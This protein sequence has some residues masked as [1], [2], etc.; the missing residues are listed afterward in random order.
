[1]TSP[2]RSILLINSPILT[3]ATLRQLVSE[4]GETT[5]LHTAVVADMPARLQ[6]NPTALVIAPSHQLD[7]AWPSLYAQARFIGLLTADTPLTAPLVGV[8]YL[9]VPFTAV[10][11]RPHLTSPRLSHIHTQ[12]QREH[13]RREKAEAFLDLYKTA[14]DNSHNIILVLDPQAHII[15]ANE[16]FWQLHHKLG[17][18]VEQNTHQLRPHDNE[19]WA[20]LFAKALVGQPFRQELRTNGHTLALAINPLVSD[21]DGVTAVAI[22]AHDITARE[23]TKQDLQRTNLKLQAYVEELAALNN[24]A[25]TV[26]K[27]TDLQA[28]LEIVAELMTTLFRA[29]NTGITLL[30]ETDQTL[31]VVADYSSHP[32]EPS[33]RGL[34]M[35]L[36]G[37]HSSWLVVKKARSIIVDDP[38]T[39]DLTESLHAL[40]RQRRTTSLMIAPL[41]AR[42]TVIGTIAVDTT[43]PDRRFTI[44]ETTLL[45]TVAVQIA[46]T[47]ENA[48]LFDEERRMR[49][50]AERQNKDLD[51]FAST[52]AHDLKSPMSLMMGFAEMLR[53]SGATMPADEIEMMA[54][55]IYI[56]GRKMISIVEEL[57]VLSSVTREEIE[58]VPIAMSA[59]V[60]Q[61]LSR[62][63]GL[64]QIY[65]GEIDMPTEWPVCLGHATWVEE[66]WVNYLSNGIKYGGRPY[67]LTLGYTYQAEDMI[68]FWVADNGEGVPQEMESEIFAEFTRL[69]QARAQGHGLGLSIVKRIVEKLGGTVGIER[70]PSPTA[71][72]HNPPNN[73]RFYFTLPVFNLNQF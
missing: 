66:V 47:I 37:N 42:G 29:R 1:M 67:Q 8:T 36:A 22:F 5:A 72:S 49:Q 23:R 4:T 48:R 43:D 38:Q 19:A 12:Y 71:V 32:G 2:T 20:Q 73:C 63:A 16:A 30:D 59:V 56:G 51:A 15:L 69:N 55:Q 10:Q 9:V 7:P 65:E 53:D 11:L 3:V 45:E 64:L 68:C 13:N 39:S 33:P 60:E 58:L 27:V 54:E 26:A 50:Q 57:L 46:N 31:T 21:I 34:V 24:I 52:V 62:L 41:L 40:M 28:A 6:T 70:L 14:F 61:A 35:P 18:T 17:F 44:E 25:R